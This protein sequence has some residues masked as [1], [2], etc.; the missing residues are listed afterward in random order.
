MKDRRKSRKAGRVMQIKGKKAVCISASNMADSGKQSISYRICELIRKI[1]D[2]DQ[3]IC[4]I[5]DLR[6]YEL[7]PCNGCGQCYEGGECGRDRDFNHVY[8]MLAQADWCFIV[9][10]H[11]A[12]VPAKLCM[13]LEKMEQ[14]TFL[15]WWKD[16]SY[17][18]KLYGKLAGIISHGGGEKWAMDSYKAMVN[19][20]IAN[21]LDTVQM[22]VVPFNSKWDTGIALS[23]K[24]VRKEDGIFPVQEYD[25][26]MMEESLY[27]Y[28]EVVVQTARSLYALK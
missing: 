25:W 14:I 12:P 17:H 6:E 18:S 27:N 28:V 4:T 9:S 13:L 1:L 24:N 20:T 23:V 16:E 15:R 2:K 5:L 11:Y 19:D 22:K 10:P 21:A 26:E 7:I 8:E 3:V